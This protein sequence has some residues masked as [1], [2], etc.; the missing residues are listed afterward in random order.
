MSWPTLGTRAWNA[1]AEPQ[2]ALCGT[3]KSRPVR[4][5]VRKEVKNEVKS[6][7]MGSIGTDMILDGR[8][9]ASFVS[10]ICQGSRTALSVEQTEMHGKPQKP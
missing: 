5:Y 2:I 9:I 4:N 8:N 1:R 3:V 6:I 10:T 7:Q